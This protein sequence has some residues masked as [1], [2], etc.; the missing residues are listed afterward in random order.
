MHFTSALFFVD[1]TLLTI[2][3]GS[4]YPPQNAASRI[5]VIPYALVGILILAM[6]VG[7]VRSLVVERGKLKSWK[8][9]LWKERMRMLAEKHREEGSTGGFGAE[10]F[11][12]MRLISKRVERKR[13]IMEVANALFAY[14]TVWFIGAMVFYYTEVRRIVIPFLTRH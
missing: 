13:S 14:L 11:E 2:G 1:Y 3:F 10:A 9:G 8:R 6:V 5:V 4:D 7:S 12:A